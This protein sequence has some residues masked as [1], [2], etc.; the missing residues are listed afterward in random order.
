MATIAAATF[1][2]QALA[3]NLPI[4]GSTVM[5]PPLLKP[6]GVL[7]RPVLMRFPA[8]AG[9]ISRAVTTMFPGKRGMAIIARGDRYISLCTPNQLKMACS[10]LVATVLMQDIDVGAF[11]DNDGVSLLD[12]RVDP[13]STRTPQEI[14]YAI[15]NFKARFGFVGRHF[16]AV[17]EQ[18]RYKPRPRT[19]PGK[20]PPVDPKL[21]AI[22]PMAIDDDGYCVY[23]DDG[24]TTALAAQAA[25]SAG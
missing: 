9:N 17:V 8:R 20:H 14:A 16:D 3:T 4:H 22:Q 11:V 5:V 21:R 25:A 18:Y 19:P 6:T 15:S 10:P 2:C 24:F 23:H 1:S 13:A 7:P 12:F